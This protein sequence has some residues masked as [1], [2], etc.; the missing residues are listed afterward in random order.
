MDRFLPDLKTLE[1][2]EARWRDSTMYERC[3]IV[4]ATYSFLL[5]RGLVAETSDNSEVNDYDG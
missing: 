3:E 2:L 5:E 4:Q 1:F